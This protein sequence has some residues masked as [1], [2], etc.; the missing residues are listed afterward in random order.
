MLT[1]PFVYAYRQ[2]MADS[3]AE[4]GR[5]HWYEPHELDAEQRALYD[6]IVARPRLQGE[7]APPLI[8]DAGRLLGPLNAMLLNPAVGGALLELGTRVR[9]S[10]RFTPRVRQIAILS[11][12][13]QRRSGFEWRAH[14][15]VGRKEGLT[16]DELTALRTGGTA[17]TFDAED[18]LV[19][20]LVGKLLHDRGLDDATFARAIAAIGEEKLMDLVSI[21]NYYDA[22][23]LSLSVWQPPYPAG[24]TAP[25]FD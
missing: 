23:A 2:D 25:A 16:E 14:E 9:F 1:L 7:K 11:V 18:T 21:V 8:D 20:E 24:V 5:L 19:R 12:A 4:H 6:R 10:T 15:R 13:G 17:P 3:N 22:V